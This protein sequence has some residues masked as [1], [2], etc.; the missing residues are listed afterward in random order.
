MCHLELLDVEL[1]VLC[2][3]FV[4]SLPGIGLIFFIA[5]C[6]GQ[7]FGFVMKTVSITQGCSSLC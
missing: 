5:A 4:L 6:M 1:Y 2:C 3:T 7:C